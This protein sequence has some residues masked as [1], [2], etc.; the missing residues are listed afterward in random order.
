MNRRVF[1]IAAVILLTSTV[2]WPLARADDVRVNFILAAPP[3][4]SEHF[5]RLANL[6]NASDAN[7]SNYNLTWAPF[8]T[9]NPEIHGLTVTP[10]TAPAVVRRNASTLEA[11][12]RV[13]FTADQVMSG[14][15]TSWWRSPVGNLAAASVLTLQLYRADASTVNVSSV[16]SSAPVFTDP[17]Q[18]SLIYS[19]H[20]GY[21]VDLSYLQPFG[22]RAYDT[23]STHDYR[24]FRANYSM[25]NGSYNFSYVAVR[26]P[27]FNAKN[28]FAFW[29]V[30]GA[31]TWPYEL[32]Y[33]EGDVPQDGVADSWIQSDS[34]PVI[35]VTANLDQSV[36]FTHGMANGIAGVAPSCTYWGETCADGG[37][38]V[39]F[40]QT[41]LSLSTV[42]GDA[43]HPTFFNMVFPVYQ[44]DAPASPSGPDVV[45]NADLWFSDGYYCSATGAKLITLNGTKSLA[46]GYWNLTY[47]GSIPG[48][49]A[50]IGKRLTR[51]DLQFTFGRPS[52]EY[53]LW[54]ASRSDTQS[55][56]MY[57]VNG[58]SG[59]DF[60]LQYHFG[61]YGY[62]SADSFYYDNTNLSITLIPVQEPDTALGK[63]QL[64]QEYTATL[65]SS[66]NCTEQLN[67]RAWLYLL[68]ATGALWLDALSGNQCAIGAVTQIATWA[69][70][71]MYFLIQG[72]LGPDL[73]RQLGDLLYAIGSWIW[74]AIQFVIKAIEWFL[75][76]AVKFIN[77]FIAAAVFAILYLSVNYASRGIFIWVKS[78]FKTEEMRGVFKEG[79]D[80]VWSVISII[81][82]MVM[83]AVGAIQAVKP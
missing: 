15:S 23:N 6:V 24:T 70:V 64:Y 25:A 14:A 67:A 72:L 1:A 3:S 10:L 76:W 30:S 9:A 2:A 50:F 69:L 83:I 20:L 79:W 41:Q 16:G 39:P 4:G 81:L 44:E 34:S 68:T 28:Y 19:W 31:G 60:G 71:G 12:Q 52:H 82:S 57:I 5:N 48:G 17:N 46:Y 36:V 11:V 59:W 77:V 21:T 35:F 13:Q 47:I 78:G 61:L 51:I 43:T 45:A 27:I 22:G 56:T 49:C 8:F 32:Y 55:L 66:T 29:E 73:T 38:G 58:T 65:T 33:T 42:I 37:G 40:I 80:R 54:L 62:F 74:Q 53:R 7:L 63:L 26:A 18:V 75:F